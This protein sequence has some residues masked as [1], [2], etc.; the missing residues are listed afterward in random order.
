S[1]SGVFGGAGQGNYAAANAYLDALAH[2]RRAH[3]L[4]AT[5]IAWG[6]WADRSAATERLAARDLARFARAG[7]APL[8]RERGLLAFDAAIAR[9]EPA[10]IGAVFDRAALRAASGEIHPLLRSLAGG[11]VR[12]AA[13]NTAEAE[14]LA[15][16]LAGA[17]DEERQRV[18][19][20]LVCAEIAT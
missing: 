17:S 1:S 12:R 19:L 16:R 2:H 13:V 15:R 20:D 6:L 3:G 9:L 18:L 5:S 8:S 4:P 10:L 14:S 7:M 11:S